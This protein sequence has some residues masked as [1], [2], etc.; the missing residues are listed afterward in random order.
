MSNKIQI[1]IIQFQNP[2]SISVGMFEIYPTLDFSCKYYLV[3]MSDSALAF[4]TIVP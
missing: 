3:K 4:S 1:S 2:E